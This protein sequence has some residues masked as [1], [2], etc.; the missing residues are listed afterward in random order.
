MPALPSLYLAMRM[1]KVALWLVPPPLLLLSL[2]TLRTFRLDHHRWPFFS[3]YDLFSLCRLGLRW[4]KQD[5]LPLELDHVHIRWEQV[6]VE[7]D[8]G[9]FCKY[10]SSFIYGRLNLSTENIAIISSMR[11]RTMLFAMHMLFEL[12]Q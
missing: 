5:L 2:A 7:L 10:Q 6:L 3:Y 1:L 4:L 9:T 11:I 12:F 8:R